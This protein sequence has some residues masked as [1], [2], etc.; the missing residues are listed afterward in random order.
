MLCLAGLPL[1]DQ[2]SEFWFTLH[3]HISISASTFQSHAPVL[4]CFLISMSF[5]LQCL[6]RV[7]LF[8]EYLITGR[9][10]QKATGNLCEEEEPAP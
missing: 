8:P 3:Q 5:S 10:I 9:E 6:R 7:G 1:L 4:T 2:V